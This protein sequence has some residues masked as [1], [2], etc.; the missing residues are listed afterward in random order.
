MGLG[1]L[2]LINVGK[3]NIFLSAQPEITYF[4]IAYKRYTNYSIE[5]TAQYFKTTPDFSRRCTVNIGKNADLIGMTYLCIILPTIQLETITNLKKF[6]W[7]EKIGIA[8]INYIEFEIGGTIID[9]HYGD[10]LNIWNELTISGGQKHGYNKMIGNIPVLTDFSLNKNKYILYVPLSFWF[11]QD[12]GLTLP[13]IALA[14][15]EIKI[16]VEFNTIDTCYNIS[17]SYYMRVTN[18]ICILQPG[19][20]IYQYYQNIKNI[21]KFIYFD[22]IN[23][24]LYYNPLVGKFIVPTELNDNKLKII[25]NISN[26]N[27]YIQPNSVIVQNEDYFKFNKP[28]FIDAYLLIDYIYLDNYERKKFINNDHEYLIQVIQTLPQ[29]ILYSVNTIYKL[30][31]YNPIKLIIWHCLTVSNNLINNKFNYTS[32]PYTEIEQDLITKNTI[33]INSINRMDLSA[34]QYYDIIQKYQYK[35]YNTQ[36]GIYLYSFALNPLELQPSGSI[37]FSKI[38]DAYISLN[39]NSIVNYQNPVFIQA[40]GVQYNIL[41]ISNGVGGLIY[42]L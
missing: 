14:H 38:D 25:G 32:Y 41:K 12:S 6:A 7:V 34:I 13:L 31:F 23:Q 22:N 36:K 18:N 30:P 4:K 24:I 39:M 17:P 8:L 9:R 37:N 27:I 26:F 21:A 40:Y 29:Q 42:I 10:W 20:I 11:C 15:N 3:E 33:V 16:H 19:E 28:S 2:T 5:Q 35:F 1:L